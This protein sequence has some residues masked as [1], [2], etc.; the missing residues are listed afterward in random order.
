[1]TQT[2]T[3]DERGYM[4]QIQKAPSLNKIGREIHK[5]TRSCCV[6]PMHSYH[7]TKFGAMNNF[8]F[9]SNSCKIFNSQHVLTVKFLS[10][11]IKY[12]IKHLVKFKHHECLL[13]N[14]LF[15]IFFSL[16]SFLFLLSIVADDSNPCIQQANTGRP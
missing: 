15:Y 11:L 16:H 6:E 12:P 13:N 2:G 3:D 8:I 7:G 4:L 14:Q 5:T 9:C 1:M 10:N